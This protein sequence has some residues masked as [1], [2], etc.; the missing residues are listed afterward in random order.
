MLAPRPRNYLLRHET[1]YGP[2][3][4]YLLVASFS[5]WQSTGLITMDPLTCKAMVL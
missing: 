2:L 5:V 3:L 4:L 1:D